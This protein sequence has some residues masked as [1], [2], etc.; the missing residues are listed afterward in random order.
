MA[1]LKGKAK[2]AFLKRMAAGRRNAKR[3]TGK[4]KNARKTSPATKKQRTAKKKR[5]TKRRRNQDDSMEAAARQFESFHGKPPNRIIEYE[6]NDTHYP[7]NLAEMGKLLEL[8]IDLNRLNRNFPLRGFKACQATCTPDGRNI[9]FIGGD[10][11]LDLSALDIGSD[12]DAVELGPC[13]RIEYHTVKGFHN[14]EPTDYNHRFGE[15]DGVLPVLCYDRLNRSLF[16]VGGNYSVR[17]EGI[18]N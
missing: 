4:K 1:K 8:R 3:A 18:V 7:D 15:E 2:E 16:L 5:P 10:Q 9:Y 6:I 11:S 13:T 17:A 12:K 14:F